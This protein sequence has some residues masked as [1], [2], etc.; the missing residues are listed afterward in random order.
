MASRNYP[1]PSL[2]APLCV[3]GL[4]YVGIP[5]LVETARKSAS[6]FVVGFDIDVNK[7]SR[8]SRSNYMLNE[9]G[10]DFSFS[11][12]QKDYDLRLTSR[13]EDI[14][15]C[16]IFIIAVPTPVDK[17]RVPDLEALISAS[18]SVSEVLKRMLLQETSTQTCLVIYEST[19]YPGTESVCYPFDFELIIEYIE[20]GYGRKN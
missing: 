3:I 14:E 18:K 11:D 20:V 9:F 2:D 7:I 4:G 5:L 10:Y 13:I 6:R 19:V 16:R 15:E 8:L 12:I 1:L 17:H